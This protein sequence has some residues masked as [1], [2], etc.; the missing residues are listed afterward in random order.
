MNEE[1][2]LA[3]RSHLQ[4]REWL[5]NLGNGNILEGVKNLIRRVKEEQLGANHSSKDKKENTNHK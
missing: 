1:N 2:R 3:V 4:E 5:L